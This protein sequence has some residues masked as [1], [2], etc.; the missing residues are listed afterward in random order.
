MQKIKN[1][2]ISRFKRL[3]NK[4]QEIQYSVFGVHR[5]R[6]RIIWLLMAIGLSVLLILFVDE[7]LYDWLFKQS[8]GEKERNINRKHLFHFDILLS[9][10]PLSFALWW[11]RTYDN[12]RASFFQASGLLGGDNSQKRIAIIQFM[13]LRNK[14]KVF[15]QEINDTMKNISLK[16]ESDKNKL[17]LMNLDLIKINFSNSKFKYIDFSDAK[18]QKTNFLGAKLENIDFSDANLQNVN[19]TYANLDIVDLKNSNL[20]NSNFFKAKVYCYNF[21]GAN[22][23]NANFSDANLERSDLSKSNLKNANF[24]RANLQCAKLCGVDLRDTTN[25]ITSN[26]EGATYDIETE[27]PPGLDTKEKRDKKGMRGKGNFP[28]HK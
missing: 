3:R 9:T 16:G 19:F 15:V 20:Q 17:D 14:E 6:G 23:R 2:I 18:L 8:V 7:C 27:F 28:Y 12:K 5:I 22:L 11:F 1:Y 4:F 25:L 21:S 24:L 10:I 26:L 13:L